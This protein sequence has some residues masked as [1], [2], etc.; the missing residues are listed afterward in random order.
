MQEQFYK[1]SG[2]FSSIFFVYYLLGILIGIPVLAAAYSYLIRYIPL[3]YLNILTAIA[4]GVGLGFIIG[5]AA[6]LGKVRNPMLVYVLTFVA[7]VILKY[8]QWAVYFPVLFMSNWPI[9]DRFIESA[10]L[11]LEPM[12][13]WENILFLN[14]FG[15]WGLSEGNS[16]SGVM[17]SL[18]WVGEFILLAGGALLVAGKFPNTPF[19][20]E[21]GAWYKK[22][23]TVMYTDLPEDSA[24]LK[25]ELKSGNLVNLKALLAKG[26]E[27]M[28]EFLTLSFLAPPEDS[29]SD[30]YFLTVI[31]TK[32]EGKRSRRGKV[33]KGNSN[34]SQ[35]VS[36]LAI[37]RQTLHE[38]TNPPV[39]ESVYDHSVDP[40]EDIEETVE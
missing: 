17:L 34:A 10:Y 31:E 30:P 2:K 39:M 15:S 38:L 3:I 1:P 32:I 25:E 9:I 29:L 33:K 13:I 12:V 16:V 21:K 19:S 27:N 4:C 22:H 24:A 23:D 20:E 11:L 40:E 26:Q 6:K 5:W 28:E 35:L 7:V 8:V 37:S 14:E 36:N 18:V